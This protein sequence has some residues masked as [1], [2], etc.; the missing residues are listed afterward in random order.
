MVVTE[1]YKLPPFDTGRYERH[2]FLMSNGNA[3][4]TVHVAGLSPVKIEFD[5]ISWHEFTAQYNCSP[6]QVSSAYFKLVD[7]V[8]SKRLI[9]EPF[10]PVVD[11]ARVM[12]YAFV[13][14]IPYRQHGGL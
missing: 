14:D 2:E 10:T 8:Q 11:R 13:D 1:I 4:L 9:Q 6:E 12:S 3:T 7:L 5:R